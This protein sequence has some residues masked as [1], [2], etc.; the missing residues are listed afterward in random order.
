[1]NIRIGLGLTHFPFE[2][3]GDFFDWVEYCETYGVDSL[4]QSDRLISQDAYL[5]SLSML[6]SLTG[7][8]QRMRFGMNVIVAP[9][10]DPLVLAKQCATIDYLSDGRLLP[11]FGVGFSQALEWRATGRDP[12]ERGARAN[13]MLELLIML[14]QED[15]VSYS[16]KFYN[17]QNASI[18]PKPLQQPLPL[19]IGGHSDAA[20]RRTARFGSGWIGGIIPVATVADTIAA[21]KR[22]LGNTGRKIDDDHY[23]ATLAFRLGHW[24]DPAVTRHPLLKRPAARDG[25]DLTPLLCVGN[26]QLLIQRIGAYIEAGATKFVLFPIARGRKDMFA[27]TEQ[28][29][30]EVL[31]AIER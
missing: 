12:G 1:M 29:V 10:R 17:Y 7:I 3:A 18:S 27:Q 24:N 23:G 31:P 28:L 15:N 5:E 16:G 6:A 4:W 22:E 21:I 13:E 30:K 20:I 14:W 2:Q 19:W 9:L 8:T 25:R 11:M 26:T